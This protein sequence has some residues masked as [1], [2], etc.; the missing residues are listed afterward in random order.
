MTC[1]G[2]VLRTKF[3]NSPLFLYTKD[4]RSNL[5]EGNR[6]CL[7]NHAEQASSLLCHSTSVTEM[8]SVCLQEP[9]P[10]PLW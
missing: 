9:R 8:A 6:I 3:G 10:L 1:L 2:N 7:M 4:K 5:L